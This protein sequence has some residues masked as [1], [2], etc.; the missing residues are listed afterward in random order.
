[1]F[2]FETQAR[3][4][5]HE[6]IAGVDEA[7]RGPLAGPVVAAAVILPGGLVIDGLTDSKKLSPKDRERFYFE[8]LDKAL[9]A[10]SHVVEPSV[11]DKI[12]VLQ[13]ALLAMVEAV[14]KLTPRP[15]Y[16]LIDGNQPIDW[17]GPQ[18]SVVK[19]DSLSYSI[20]AASVIAK[21]TRDRLM[22]EYG[23]RYPEYGF[24]NHKGYGAKTH[25]AAIAKYGPCPIHRK[26]FRGVREYLSIEEKI[27][28]G[29]RQID[30]L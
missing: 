16:T 8:I 22:V 13:A 3:N 21:V 4:L 9:S 11:V 2:T 23:R 15:D 6:V 27:S 24:E 29:E 19:G 12:N 25:K 1:M 14:K 17:A 5:G 18:K 7:G 10:K 20:A 26:T 28:I 30:I